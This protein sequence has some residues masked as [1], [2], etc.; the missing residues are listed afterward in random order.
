[1]F[2]AKH[3]MRIAGDL[4]LEAKAHMGFIGA[5]NPDLGV[6]PFERFVMGGSGLAGTQGQ[7][8]LG[9]D[10]ISMRGYDDNSLTPTDPLTNDFGGTVYNKIGLELRYPLSLKPAATIYV[11]GFAEAGNNWLSFKDYD[12]FNMFRTAG[13]GARIFMPAF[14]LL[15]IDWGIAFDD[16]IGNLT[17]THQTFQFTLGQ[18]FR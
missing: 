7:F 1:M 18:Q 13:I 9:S 5:Y 2:D 16:Q 6:G 10:I 17:P 8:I 12:P 14:G 15:G 4:V 3:Y 11:L